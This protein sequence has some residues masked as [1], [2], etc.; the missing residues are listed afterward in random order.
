MADNYK[1]K[2]IQLISNKI[3]NT[4]LTIT[5]GFTRLYGNQSSKKYHK[6][7]EEL[8]DILKKQD[9]GTASHSIRVAQIAEALAKK[10][11]LSQKEIEKIKLSGRLHDLGKIYIPEEILN[12]PGPLTDKEYKY[13]KKH[14]GI[15]RKIIEKFPE[16][17]KEASLVRHHHE[18]FNGNGYP[19]G[20]SK[21]DIPLGSRIIA[22]AD[23]Y[24]AMTSDR[25][26]RKALSK[27]EALKRIRDG[28]GTQFD[29]IIADAFMQIVM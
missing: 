26:Y 16:Y 14:P 1:S 17:Q 20:L 15:G 4:I 10:M 12:K 22:L 5:T 2:F 3:T 9:Q 24:D 21:Y 11:K 8:N 29:P 7:L 23:A 27:E 6:Q 18:W 25:V 13:M 28:Q 19:K